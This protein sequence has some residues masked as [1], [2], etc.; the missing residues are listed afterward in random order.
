M[1]DWFGLDGKVAV[2]TGGASG[3][4][5]ATAQRLEDAGATVVIADLAEAD[6]RLDAAA[7]AAIRRAL[8][9]DP[10]G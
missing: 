6:G 3:I 9:T 8:E 1:T 7:A 4:G 5:H 2:I 10:A